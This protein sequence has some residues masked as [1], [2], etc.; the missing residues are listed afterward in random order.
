MHVSIV[1]SNTEPEIH[2]NGLMQ[3]CLKCTFWDVHM[4]QQ[5]LL[6]S[7]AGPS[8]AMI[9]PMVIGASTMPSPLLAG[10]GL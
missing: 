3:I 9:E 7:G 2:T 5:G 8:N 10:A 6:T 4:Q 1:T